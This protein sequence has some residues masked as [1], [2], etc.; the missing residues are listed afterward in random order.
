V[1]QAY[2]I[3]FVFLSTYSGLSKAKSVSD[4]TSLITKWLQSLLFLNSG[5]SYKEAKLSYKNSFEVII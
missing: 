4:F 5:A 3:K 2:H 1:L